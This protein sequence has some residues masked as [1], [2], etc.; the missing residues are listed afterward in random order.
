MSELSPYQWPKVALLAA[1][2]LI[3]NDGGN[4]LWQYVNDERLWLHVGE[5]ANLTLSMFQSETYG[6]N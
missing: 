6:S 3:K 1:K 2:L 5:C 4:T